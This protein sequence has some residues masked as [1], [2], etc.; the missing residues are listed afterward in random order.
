MAARVVAKN[1]VIVSA[2]SLARITISPRVA[3][4][5]AKMRQTHRVQRFDLAPFC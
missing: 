1:S 4:V 3:Y 2:P 5:N